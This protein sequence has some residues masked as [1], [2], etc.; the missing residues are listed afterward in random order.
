MGGST[1]AG[2][3]DVWKK[4]FKSDGMI[5]LYR[6]FGVSVCGIFFYRGLQFGLYDFSKSDE[7]MNFWRLFLLGYA[8][9][10]FAEV[11]SYPLDTL[12]RRMMMTSETAVKYD[13]SVDCLRQII[14]KEGGRSLFKGCGANILRAFAGAIV[15]VGFDELKQLYID[16]FLSED[17]NIYDA[18]YMTEKKDCESMD[19]DCRLAEF[20]LK[21][22]GEKKATS[23][24]IDFKDDN[25]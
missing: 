4:T 18:T 7:K 24:E 11:V 1:Q 19:A 9:T 3:G 20:S 25:R 12:R 17:L 21:E 10:T 22:T 23:D 8:T 15:L 14:K 13:S 2:L 5:G 16:N 6:G